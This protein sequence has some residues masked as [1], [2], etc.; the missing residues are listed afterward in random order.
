MR[1]S[2]AGPSGAGLGAWASWIASGAPAPSYC[3]GAAAAATAAPRMRLAAALL[4][5]LPAAQQL[6]SL[7]GQHAS[8]TW[9]HPAAQQANASSSGSMAPAAAATSQLARRGGFSRGGSNPVAQQYAAVGAPGS[10]AQQLVSLRTFRGT[11]AEQQRMW[12][13][14]WDKRHI[15]GSSRAEALGVVVS[16]LLP[17]VPHLPSD[18]LDMGLLH[19]SLLTQQILIAGYLFDA[20]SLLQEKLHEEVPVVVPAAHQRHLWEVRQPLGQLLLTCCVETTIGC[21]LVCR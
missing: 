20:A 1:G 9:A 6:L 17:A 13:G 11:A 19:A 4:P 8:S 16:H 21:W 10:A 2:L 7:H 15:Y 3:S 5:W 12:G 14:H 18:V